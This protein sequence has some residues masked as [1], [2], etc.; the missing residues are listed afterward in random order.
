[1]L[2]CENSTGALRDASREDAEQRFID[3]V[4][5]LGKAAQAIDPSIDHCAVSRMVRPGEVTD[6]MPRY[7]MFE[8]K[9]VA[10]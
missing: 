1:M 5:A 10:A 7:V 9:A 2:T 4:I 8:R 3:A 6:G